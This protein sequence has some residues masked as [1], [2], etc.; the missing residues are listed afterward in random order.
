M[1]RQGG[2]GDRSYLFT[3][4]FAFLEG[5][6]TDQTHLVFSDLMRNFINGFQ[7]LG[8]P[9][10]SRVLNV[11]CGSGWLSQYFSQLGY[12]TIGIEIPEEM[13]EAARER[14]AKVPFLHKSP[15]E[16]EAMFA[17]HDIEWSPLPTK[18]RFD[19]AI[20]ESCL[21]H[22]LDP[23]AAPDNIRQMLSPEGLVLIIEGANRT[24]PIKE[25]Y[26]EVMRRYRTLERQYSRDQLVRILHA[27]GPP[28]YEFLAPV[29][30]FYSARSMEAAA[31]P[32]EVEAKSNNANKCVCAARATALRRILPWWH[33]DQNLDFLKGFAPGMESKLWCAPYGRI[34]IRRDLP[35]LALRIGTVM[36]ANSGS[37]QC[38]TL[39]TPDAWRRH[40]FRSGEPDSI[41]VTLP[42]EC[43]GTEL[44]L[45]SDSAFT[46]A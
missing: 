39:Y 6:A 35:T 10:G 24:G 36:P 29:N 9:A 4:P 43:A 3:K 1:L 23:I 31:L 33:A 40:V 27:A 21:H 19:A 37:P 15:E 16:I 28:F 18:G 20:L 12:Q 22:F 41:I 13:I 38:V 5:A 25:E 7:L 42:G 11:A 34:A 30:A 17:V 45:C 14:L 2:L 44:H 8:L 26:L 46:P 32:N